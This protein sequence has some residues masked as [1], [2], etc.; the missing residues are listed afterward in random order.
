MKRLLLL[1]TLFSFVA[2]G[3]SQNDPKAK[4]ILDKSS[5]TFKSY[6]TIYAE[7]ELKNES[8]AGKA[9]GV[10]S[11]KMWTKG[12]KFYVELGNRKIWSD[13]KYIYNADEDTKEIT[14][15]LAENNESGFTPQ[16]I[17]TNF[18]D[19]D[20]LYRY[21]SEGTTNGRAVNEIEMTPKDKSNQFHKL[22]LGIDKATNHIS[23]LK[24][25]NKAGN[26]ITYQINKLVP[27]S[28][29]ND[30][31]FAYNSKDYPGY[32]LLDF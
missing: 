29:V 25:L 26:K 8:A 30:T 13:G 22:Y 19:K 17:F 21:N 20:F 31:K 24:L 18:Y 27:N 10:E 16:K 9:L 7:F 6:K 15:T 2:L 4:T 28:T 14:K 23:F 3:Y 12:S 11:G 32:E 5:S 1:V